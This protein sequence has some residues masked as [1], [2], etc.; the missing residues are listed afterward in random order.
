MADKTPNSFSPGMDC[1]NNFES[2]DKLFFAKVFTKI[3]ELKNHDMK[4][5]N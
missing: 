4:L 1:L 5:L 2:L 3:I